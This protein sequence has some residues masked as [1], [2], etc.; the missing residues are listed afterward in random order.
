MRLTIPPQCQGRDGSTCYAHGLQFPKQLSVAERVMLVWRVV[1]LEPIPYDSQSLAQWCIDYLHDH[2]DHV[3]DIEASMAT[4]HD[5]GREDQRPQTVVAP[6]AVAPRPWMDTSSA[7]ASRH[8]KKSTFL[9]ARRGPNGEWMFD[10][11][12]ELRFG[13]W[14]SRL[15]GTSGGR[16]G[17]TFT[18]HRATT[19][20]ASN[21]ESACRVST[22]TSH[23]AGLVIS[24]KVDRRNSGE[25]P[26]TVKNV[27]IYASVS[28]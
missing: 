15:L 26:D 16:R 21:G 25:N 24:S 19:A 1:A 17:S 4:A 12:T 18:S 11:Q 23:Q 3:N 6:R 2:E 8:R 13:G 7:T 9:T 22:S 10:P 5:V 20:G 27:F 14:A 28:G